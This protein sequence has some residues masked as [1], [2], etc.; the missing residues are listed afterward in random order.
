M[1]SYRLALYR[2]YLKLKKANY[3]AIAQ[4]VRVFFLLLRLLPPD[5]AIDVADWLGRNLGPLSSRHRL[6]LDNL[7]Q[8]FPEKTDDEIAQI[9]RRMWGQMGRLMVEYLFVD[10]LAAYDPANGD[11]GR[12]EITG[13]D[14]VA[15]IAA[16]GGRARIFFT[17]HTGNFELVPIAA[18]RYDIRPTVL[19]RAPNNPY[20]AD[21]LQKL[22]GNERVRLLASRPGVAL[23]L[24]RLLEDGKSIGMLVDQKF[25]G[26]VRGNFFGREC[27]TSPLLSKLAAKI[28]CDIY[29]CRSVR[30]PGNRYR[31]EVNAPITLPRSADGKT[32]IAASVQ[33]LNDIIEGWVR[34]FPEQWMWI[35]RRWQT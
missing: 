11:D 35:H 9:A 6:A 13:L 2:A 5:R 8:A 31:I 20:L 30:L 17:A 22:R 7:K 1:S 12:L 27:L 10:T 26:G 29:P 28:D 34:E 15:A 19:Y 25:Y 32:D 21:M 24:A 16:D 18:A 23:S 4:V 33:L 14:H 3:W